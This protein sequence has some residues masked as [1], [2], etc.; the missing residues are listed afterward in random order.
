MCGVRAHCAIMF[1][2]KLNSVLTWYGPVDSLLGKIKFESLPDQSVNHHSRLLKYKMKFPFETN[3]FNITK[4]IIRLPLKCVNKTGECNHH[5]RIFYSI[6]SNSKSSVTRQKCKN[7]PVIIIM[8]T[9]FF[10][11]KMTLF[12][13]ATRKL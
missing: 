10:I 6:H 11:N 8:L 12:C 4:V 3:S 1:H 2:L 9:I 7:S 13:K 5:L